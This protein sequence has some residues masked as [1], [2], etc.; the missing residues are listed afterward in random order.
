M[1]D[2]S[3]RRTIYRKVVGGLIQSSD[4]Y[5]LLGKKQPGTG[6]DGLWVPPGGGIESGETPQ[7]ALVREVREE[8]GLDISNAEIRFLCD[9]RSQEIEKTLPT[10]GE[11]VRVVMEVVDFHILIPTAKDSL[12]VAG[13]DD[14]AQLSWFNQAELASIPLSTTAREALELLGYL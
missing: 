1:S 6:F 2:G 3:D 8:T 4:N 9:G 10:T 7:E 13:Q 11:S 14:M 12:A 5:F